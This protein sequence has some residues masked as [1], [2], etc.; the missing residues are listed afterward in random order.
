MSIVSPN[1]LASYLLPEPVLVVITGP[2]G[3][4]KDS[5]IAEMR[6]QGAEFQFIVTTTDRPMRVGEVEGVDYYFVSTAE[7]QR[8]IASDELFEHAEVYNQ[9][10]GVQKRHVREAVAAGRDT[11]MR[12]DIRGARTIKRQ[13]PGAVTVFVTPPSARDL[14]ERL[15]VRGTDQP[16]Q[17]A[18][19]LS[20]AE[21][22]IAVAHTFDYVVIN[23]T[24][25]LCDAARQ[26]LAIME[27]TR[28]RTDRIPLEL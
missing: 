19:R 25:Q 6:R 1:P 14:A 8:L 24:G 26:V 15:S 5:V 22:E 23:R 28:C 21:E 17:M 11:V 2:S 9:F 4:G 27:A 7:F 10:K 20:I 16:E 12:V 3:A 13:L 18:H